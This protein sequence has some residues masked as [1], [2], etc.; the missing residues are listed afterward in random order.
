MAASLTHTLKINIGNETER[1][2]RN[3]EDINEESK[4]RTL[5]VSI[6]T[7]QNLTCD[8]IDDTAV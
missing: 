1:V 7:T 6:T 8:E 3:G 5:T 4:Q 2:K